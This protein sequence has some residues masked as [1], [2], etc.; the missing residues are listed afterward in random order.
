M[1]KKE[2]RVLFIFRDSLSPN[3]GTP[4]R[5]KSLINEILKDQDILAYTATRD[6]KSVLKTNHLTLGTNNIKNIFLCRDYIK[7]NKIDIVVFHTIAAGYFLLPL[8]ILGGKYK[9]VLEMHGF[10]EEEAVLYNDISFFKYYRNKVLYGCIYKLC[11]LITTC[12]D[13]ARERLLKYNRNVHTIYGGVDLA[14]FDLSNKERILTKSAKIIIGY[15]GNGRKWQGL[16]FLLA[17]FTTLKKH[18]DGF[19]LKLL[20]S[21]K[22]NIPPTPGVSILPALPHDQVW[23]FNSECDILVIP[24]PDNVVNKISFPS[25]LMEYL[26]SGKVVVGSRTSDIH[27][28]IT[29][30]ETGMLYAPGDIDEFIKCI[31]ELKDPLLRENIAKKGFELCSTKYTWK[32]QGKLFG[33]LIKALH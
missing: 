9:R 20:L 12:S 3:R 25:K 2:I 29:H 8:L 26:A 6:L 33:R 28:I 5:V 13:T 7:R 11:H 22:V 18:D 4:L 19:E 16:D 15:A 31:L 1:D 17:A 32:I 21:E 23:R 14:L 27:R 24:R 10:F 30:K